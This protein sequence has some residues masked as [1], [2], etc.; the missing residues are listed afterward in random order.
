[1]CVHNPF[2]GNGN[3]LC[4]FGENIPPSKQIKK[5]QKQPNFFASK[6]KLAQ[7]I[8]ILKNNFMQYGKE[9]YSSVIEFL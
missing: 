9:I 7:A 4:G 6:K 5:C 8:V 2:K 3:Y 1:M